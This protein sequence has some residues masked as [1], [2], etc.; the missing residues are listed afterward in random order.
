VATRVKPVGLMRNVANRVK[1]AAANRVLRGNFQNQYDELQRQAEA[2]NKRFRLVEEDF[3]PFLY[4][5]TAALGFDRH[6]VYHTAWAARKIAAARPYVHVDISSLL[7]FSTLVSAFVPVEFY[8][9]RPATVELSGLTSRRADL[10]NLP[11]DSHSITSLSCMHTVEH[12]GLGR[13]GDK[14]DYDGD[15]K[16]MRSL[17]RVLAPG[18]QLLFVVPVAGEPRIMFNAHRIYEPSMVIEV[19]SREGLQLQEF[20]LI[21]DDSDS[22]LIVAPDH[23]MMARQ[24]YGCGCFQFTR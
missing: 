20:A 13:Y 8:D 11:F 2:G 10:C 21:A 7:Y 17:S 14:L 16:A 19:F 4:D 12:V 6:Y 23:D 22:G 15:L 5:S 24:R 1:R 18:G 9:Y 3:L